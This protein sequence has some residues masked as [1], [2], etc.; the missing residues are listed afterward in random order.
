MKRSLGQRRAGSTIPGFFPFSPI[1]LFNLRYEK[2]LS[3]LDQ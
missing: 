1:F 2:V 3:A